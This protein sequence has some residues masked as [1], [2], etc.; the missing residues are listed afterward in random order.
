M[1]NILLA[2]TLT[3]AAGSAFAQQAPPRAT[4][5]QVDARFAPWVG[6]WRLED[7]LAGTGARMCITPDKNGVR[8]Q[9]IVG[10]NRGIDELVI[11][12]GVAH[13]ITD[14]ECQGTE[15][16]DWSKDGNFSS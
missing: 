3:L 10:T 9:T 15:Q 12:D 14:K 7:D 5:A 11:P 13:P 6:C 8:L 1:K 2:L 16:A 4:T